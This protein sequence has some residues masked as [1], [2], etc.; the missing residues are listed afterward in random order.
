MVL[1]SFVKSFYYSIALVAN[2]I[3]ITSQIC[4]ANLALKLVS[5]HAN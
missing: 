5:T 2:Y 4:M 1:S 3:K